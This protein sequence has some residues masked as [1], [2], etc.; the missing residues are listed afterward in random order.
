[1]KSEIVIFISICVISV[2]AEK[3]SYEGFSV[4]KVTPK[5][6][7]DLAVLNDLHNNGLGEFW[8]DQFYV[9][10]EV[11]VMVSEDNK[12]NFEHILNQA[13]I[14]VKLSIKDVKR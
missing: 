4:Y 5:S 10:Y 7:N 11:R 14:D 12:V 8:E 13:G 2:F 3:K 9:N 6:E 1:M